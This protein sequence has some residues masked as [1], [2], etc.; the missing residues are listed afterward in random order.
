MV[1]TLAIIFQENNLEEKLKEMID[2]VKGSI[3]RSENMNTKN[4][5]NEAWNNGF[6]EGL[7]FG[8]TDLEEL[9][10]TIQKE[11]NV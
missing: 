9:L 6:I 8:L 10:E 4:E 3:K 1:T 7:E 11:K 2:N 5:Y